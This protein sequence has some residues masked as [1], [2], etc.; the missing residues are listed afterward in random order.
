MKKLMLRPPAYDELLHLLAAWRV[1]ISGAVLGAAVASIVYLIAPP[2]Y[3]AQATVLVD[4]NVEQVIPL[5]QTDLSKNTYLQ[6]ETDKLVEIV[7][8]DHTLSRVTTQTGLSMARLRDGRLHLSQ[9]S[10]GGWH[11]LADAPDPGSAS[12]L[13][14]AW[15]E[16]FVGEIQSRPA[17]ISALLEINFTQQQNLPIRRAVSIGI[18][19]FSGT[20]LGITLLMLALLFVDWKHA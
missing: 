6:R 2:P 8:S 10:D 13:A 15:A 11:F 17:G 18:Y 7:W 12:A 20:L 14:S 1:W 19:I 3:R 4:Q 5:E 16:A 9:P